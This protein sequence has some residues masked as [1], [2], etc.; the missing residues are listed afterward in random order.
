MRFDLIT[1]NLV[2]AIADTRS[3]TRGAAHEHLA[4]AAA[5]KRL[6]DLESRLGV[7]LFERR[8]RGVDLTEAGRALVRHIR[9]LNAS[10]HALESEVVEFSRGIKGH[11]RIA[12]NASAITECLP[13]DLAAF[14]QAHPGIRIS[15]EDLTSAEVQAAVAEGR[16]DVGIF[17]PPQ[18]DGRLSSRHYR[19]GELAVLVPRDHVL[20]RRSGVPFD[21]LLDFDIVGLHLGAAVHEQMRERAQALGR[22]LNVR[23]QV[24]GFDAIAQLVEA[25]LGV[26]VLPAVVA[27]RFARIFAVQPLA[28]QEDWA[29]RPYLL[30]VRTQEVLPAVVQ[31]FVESL[32]PPPAS[33]NPADTPAPAAAAPQSHPRPRTP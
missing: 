29:K 26:A 17:V 15:L 10:L 20:A 13:A 2:L 22:T 27:Q 33:S 8:A 32:C 7:A 18:H 5:S 23:L 30:A 11:L 25:G 31:R 9:S 16:A 3:I 21:A 24:R 4:L 1:L 14:S 6:S 19:D 12:A 28:L